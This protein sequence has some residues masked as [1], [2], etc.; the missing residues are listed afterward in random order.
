MGGSIFRSSLLAQSFD[1]KTVTQSI[2]I[3]VTVFFIVPRGESRTPMPCDTRFCGV[4]VPEVGLEPTRLATHDFESCVSA[5]PPLRHHLYRTIFTNLSITSPLNS[6]PAGRHH[7]SVSNS[8][9]NAI[10]CRNQR[11]PIHLKHGR[12]RQSPS[13]RT[14]FFN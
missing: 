2:A 10:Y 1:T 3:A 12:K 4:L 13:T 6:L 9:C 11:T 7:P 14:Y 5:I 8:N